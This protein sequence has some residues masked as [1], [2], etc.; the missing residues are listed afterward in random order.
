MVLLA[1]WSITLL[2][3]VL[4]GIL[5]SGGVFTFA[6]QDFE[7]IMTTVVIWILFFIPLAMWPF[8]TTKEAH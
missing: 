5:M 6:Y 1:L 7:S 8:G 2:P 4:L 3:G